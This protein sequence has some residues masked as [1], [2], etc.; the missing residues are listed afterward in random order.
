ML[1]EFGN[2]RTLV[3][4]TQKHDG[5]CALCNGPFI[6][7]TTQEWLNNNTFSNKATWKLTERCYWYLNWKLNL[8]QSIN[9]PLSGQQ[10][11]QG[12]HDPHLMHS[13]RSTILRIDRA[14]SFCS[15]HMDT[16]NSVTIHL[17][18]FHSLGQAHEYLDTLAGAN[19]SAN[20]RYRLQFD[21]RLSIYYWN[22][23]QNSL[24]IYLLFCFKWSLK[25]V[26]KLPGHTEYTFW[27][28]ICLNW[29]VREDHFPI[30]WQHICWFK[31]LQEFLWWITKYF[32][33]YQ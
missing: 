33:E 32:V 28:F 24:F 31:S 13:R 7:L 14:R 21:H 3:W 1:L 15:F 12:N 19:P 11:L 29:T 22:K 5:S 23:I 27:L 8:N 2:G 9:Y 10:K 18:R 26:S 4:C 17:L 20:N 30:I 6:L 25:F 16:I